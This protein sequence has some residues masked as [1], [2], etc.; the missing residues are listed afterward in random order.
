M[1]FFS[2][3]FI[4][5]GWLI[6]SVTNHSTPLMLA[7]QFHCIHSLIKSTTSSRLLLADLQEH[8]LGQLV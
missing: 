6:S 4:L 3:I 7:F 8:N 1:E 5:R 2:L